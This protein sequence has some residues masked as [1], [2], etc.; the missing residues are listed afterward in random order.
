MR[1]L[2][3]CGVVAL[4]AGCADMSSVFAPHNAPPPPDPH[5]QMAALETRIYELIEED[6]LKLDP[7]AKPLA[8]DSELMGVAREKS[9]DMAAKSYLAHQSPDGATTASIIMGEDADFQGLLGENIAA[10]NYVKQTGVDV[11]TYAHR[12]VDSWM[13][14]EAHRK[15]L[16]YPSYDRTGVG[17]AVNGDTVYVTQLFATDLGLPP[18]EQQHAARNVHTYDDPKSAG[19]ASPPPAAPQDAPQVVPKP[20]PGA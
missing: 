3:V 4:L 1:L 16:A 6:R 9:A 15:N 17:A 7:R 2:W 14:S 13:A 5:T 11:E 12:F 18:P 20:K 8:L 10:Q 19:D